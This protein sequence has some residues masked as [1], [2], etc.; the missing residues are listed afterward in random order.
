MERYVSQFIEDLHE[1]TF[2]MNPPLGPWGKT[3]VGENNMPEQ[4]DM[5]CDGYELD[6]RQPISTATGIDTELLPPGLKLSIEQQALLAFELEDFLKYFT[7]YLNFPA[8]Y[9]AHLRYSFI[10]NLW[11][12]RYECYVDGKTHIEF[13]DYSGN[14]CP[15]PGYCSICDDYNQM[16]ASNKRLQDTVD[17]ND[18]MF[19]FGDEEDNSP[20]KEDI[21]GF[22]DDDGNKIDL[23][24]IPVPNLCV[25]CRSY[26]IDD[27][28]ENLLC[29]MNRNDQRNK[30]EF[31]CGA[32]EKE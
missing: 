8:I 3:E 23:K 15:F 30:K 6:K 32:F 22:Y 24:T 10:R 2:K 31:V 4:E 20:Y 27:W 26:H 7:I 11:E 21:N 1:V 16:Q 12:E 5:Y 28:D 25:I 9:P 18:D 14:N 17:E 29:L 13:C 19:P